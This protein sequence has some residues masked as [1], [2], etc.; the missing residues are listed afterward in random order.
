MLPS[1]ARFLFMKRLSL[2]HL[3]AAIGAV[4]L[5]GNA[6]GA[7]LNTRP[8]GTNLLLQFQGDANDDWRLQYSADLTNWTT[9]TNFGVL[10]SGKATNAPWRSVGSQSNGV[11]FF[12]GEK[13]SGLFD[14]AVFHNVNLTF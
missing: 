4:Y 6:F 11:Q 3:V 13:T 14:P 7:Q 5:A 12:R 9:L 10:L 8:D 1:L 2:S